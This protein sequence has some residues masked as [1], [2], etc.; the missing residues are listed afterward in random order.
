MTRMASEPLSAYVRRTLGGGDG[1]GPDPDWLADRIAELEATI[2][3]AMRYSLAEAHDE[4]FAVLKADGW[5]VPE[6][7]DDESTAVPNDLLARVMEALGDSH[8]AAVAVALHLDGPL[9]EDPDETPWTRFVGPAAEQALAVYR[10]LEALERDRKEKIPGAP[11]VCAR[12]GHSWRRDGTCVVCDATS[13]EAS[14]TIPRTPPR[15]KVWICDG[16]G[17]YTD[18]PVEHLVLISDWGWVN[19]GGSMYCEECC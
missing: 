15:S 6:L 14:A 3:R 13:S 16:C 11:A 1:R 5:E 7:A 12:H 10:E 4:M 2:D 9:N 17:S 18:H 19:D 8:A